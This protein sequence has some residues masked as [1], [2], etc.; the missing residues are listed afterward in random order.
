MFE[1]FGL[2]SFCTPHHLSVGG[3]LEGHKADAFVVSV[4]VYNKGFG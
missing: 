3:G 1:H 2:K 4:L